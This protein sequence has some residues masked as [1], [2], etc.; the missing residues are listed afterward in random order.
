[1]IFPA[2]GGEMVKEFSLLDF[3]ISDYMG[4]VV[5]IDSIGGS[6]TLKWLTVETLSPTESRISVGKNTTGRPRRLYINRFED[7]GYTEIMIIQLR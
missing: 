2:E 7:P 6:W 3:E 4:D 1:M 5:N